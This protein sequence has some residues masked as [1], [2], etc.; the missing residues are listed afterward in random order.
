MFQGAK[1]TM[2]LT[3]VGI[4]A[5]LVSGKGRSAVSRSGCFMTQC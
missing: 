4:A 3:L 1:L 2:T 5:N